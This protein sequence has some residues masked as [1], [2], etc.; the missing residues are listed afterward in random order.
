VPSVTNH[1]LMSFFTTV[2]NDPVCSESMVEV[3][4][5]DTNP[6]SVKAMESPVK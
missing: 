6:G 1:S 4:S 2:K 5:M 3:C